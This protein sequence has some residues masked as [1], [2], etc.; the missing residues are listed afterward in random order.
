ML[1]M[2]M[3]AVDAFRRAW[4]QVVENDAEDGVMSWGVER[5]AEEADESLER[6]STELRE[7]AYVPS[8]LTEFLS[9]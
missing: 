2:E 7:G 4:E 6:L 9:R 1:T 3:F 8:D 5:F